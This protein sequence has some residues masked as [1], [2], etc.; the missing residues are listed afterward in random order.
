MSK[1]AQLAHGRLSPEFVIWHDEDPGAALPEAVGAVSRRHGGTDGPRCAPPLGRG[2]RARLAAES[3]ADF[4]R[5]GRGATA[6]RQRAGDAAFHRAESVEAGAG[7]GDRRHGT[8]FREEPRKRKLRYVAGVKPSTAPIAAPV[9]GVSRRGATSNSK[10]LS[11][12]PAGASGTL[13]CAT[14]RPGIAT[15]SPIQPSRIR[16]FR[17]RPAEAGSGRGSPAERREA[18]FRWILSQNRVIKKCKVI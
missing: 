15:I 14:R 5:A 9:R 13:A 18:G 11:P 2:L 17:G 3:P 6:R 1:G 7:L 4:G 12:N 16:L 8:E 10:W